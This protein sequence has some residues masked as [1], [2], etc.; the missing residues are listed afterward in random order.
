[1]N[2]LWKLITAG[3]T[4]ALCNM[5]AQTAPAAFRWPQGKRV[6]VSLSFDDGRASQMDVGLPLFEKYGAKVT[7]YV[8]PKNMENRLQAWK[9]AAAEGYEIANHTSTHPCSGNFPWSRN[10][11]LENFTPAMIEAEMDGANADA[12]RLLGVKPVNFAYPCGQKFIGRGEAAASYVPLVA[13]RFRTGRGF[14]DEG[15]NDPAFCD[16]SQLYGVESDGM[17]FAG[18]RQAVEAAAKQGAWLVF[19]GHDIGSPHEQTTQAA[20]LE[21]FLKYAAD[22]ANGVWLDTVD[23]IARYVQSQRAGR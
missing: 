7:F 4:A 8:N 16:L 1:M 14:R 19:A 9:R 11:A 13:K 6:A 2:T 18:L 17:S 23:N 3:L 12:E 20:A 10:N 15:P 5:A 21:Q 22:P